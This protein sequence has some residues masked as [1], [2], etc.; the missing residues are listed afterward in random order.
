MNYFDKDITNT[1]EE[2]SHSM[3]IN[4]ITTSTK[5][6]E[7]LFEC[8]YWLKKISS[9]AQESY[10]KEYLIN[11]RIFNLLMLLL[12]NTEDFSEDIFSNIKA[13]LK[14]I[15]VYKDF[16][17]TIEK[18]LVYEKLFNENLSV[19][20]L[21]ILKKFYIII[22]KNERKS[23]FVNCYEGLDEIF[24]IKIA[25]RSS[26]EIDASYAN[27]DKDWYKQDIAL[28]KRI[29]ARKSIF[30][31]YKK[32]QI[33]IKKLCKNK[34]LEPKISLI[35][36]KFFDNNSISMKEERHIRSFLLKNKF[37]LDIYE[38]IDTL[39]KLVINTYYMNII[40]N[41][42][43]FHYILSFLKEISENKNQFENSFRLQSNPEIISN[44]TIQKF[45]DIK[46]E[47][48]NMTKGFESW[49]TNNHTPETNE[50]KLNQNKKL[51]ALKFAKRHL[52]R[53]ANKIYN[54]KVE[55][56]Q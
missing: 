2:E 18:P 8:F 48:R 47:I 6:R 40:D 20:E 46:F 45:I 52:Y 17:E 28:A 56:K 24:K 27:A 55:Q 21:N 1:N 35:L 13:V 4:P 49:I 12:L 34:K 26:E 38:Q 42:L 32:H 29:I 50:I 9:Y 30:R 14:N 15:D 31:F 39:T 54:R 37:I 16:Y 33:R 53:R 3:K 23:L 7:L 43:D 25:A 11:K 5:T 10:T 41:G 36:N 44:E 19:S 22:D 51:I